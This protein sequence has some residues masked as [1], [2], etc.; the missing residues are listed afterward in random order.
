[1]NIILERFQKILFLIYPAILILD[2][3]LANNFMVF[4]LLVLVLGNI[5]INKKIIFT[6]YEKFMLIFVIA[7]L[8]SIIFKNTTTNSGLVMIERHFRWLILPTFLGQL[9]IKKEDIKYMFF[10]VFFGILG[11]TY[12]VISEMINLKNPEFSWLEFFKSSLPWNYRYLS[13]YSI[14][15]S[16]LILGV[17]FIILYYVICINDEKKYKLF[18]L[19][20]LFLSGIILMSVQ[21]RGMTLTLFI[22]VI[23]LGIIRK[24]KI[25]RIVSGF[26]IVFSIIGGIYFSNSHYVQ[27]Y[28]NLGKDSSSLARVEVY[29]EAFRLFEKNKINGVGLEGFFESQETKNYRYYEKYRHPHNM[30]LKLLAE[31]GIIGFISYYLFVGSILINLWKKY[32]ENEYFLIGILA[33]L[34]LVLYEN[35]ETMFTKAIALPYVFFIIGIN[36]NQIYRD[37]YLEKIKEK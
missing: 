10:S 25:I 7:V 21:S 20:G 37:K 33:L 31:T 22:L 17:T 23:F 19:L 34:T 36:L 29:K 30:A 11:Y 15:Q 13:E 8:I 18:L 9:K 12:R 5:Y 2:P 24:E 14:P 28:E 3:K 1:M 26:I 6:F 4:I 32:K 27:R 16:A 35:I